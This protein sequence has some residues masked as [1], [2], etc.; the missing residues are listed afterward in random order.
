MAETA[1]S[2]KHHSFSKKEE[3][4]CP[5]IIEDSKN[6]IKYRRENLLGK[7]GLKF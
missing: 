4:V 7:G 5:D 6:K 2:Q 3:V 1:R